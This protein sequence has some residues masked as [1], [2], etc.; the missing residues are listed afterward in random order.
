MDA[1]LVFVTLY[2]SHMHVQK[3]Q[4]IR[5]GPFEL[6]TRSGELM[7][8]GSRISLQEQ[9]FQ[10]LVMLL[11]RPGEVVTRQEFNK[12]MWPENTF[13]DFER[14]LNKAINKL[15]AAL[16]DKAGKPRYIETLPQ[17][18]YRFVAPVEK[19]PAAGDGFPARHPY[20]ID[21]LA[22]LPLANHTGDPAQ[23]YFS[24]GLT[25]ELICAIS[26]I[27][28]LRVISRTS[29]MAFK[30]TRKSLSGI[31]RELAVDAVV[32]GSVSRS[33]DRVRVTAQLIRARDDSHLWAGRYERDL[34]DILHLQAEVAQ[35]IATQINKVIDPQRVYADQSRHVDPRAYE[36]F[37]KGNYFRDKVEPLALL[38]SLECYGR[39]V[40]LDPAYARAHGALSVAYFYLGLFGVEPPAMMF[41]KA[42]ASAARALELDETVA[43][44]HIGMAVVHVLYDWDWASAERECKRALELSPGEPY[45]Y[46]H[47]ADYLSI[48]GHHAEAIDVFR[49]ALELDPISRLYIGFFGL[50]LH[51]A[52]RYDESIAQCQKALEID[53]HYVNAMWFMALSLEQKGGM[54]EAIAK[55]E[56]AVNLVRAPHFQGLLGWNYGR[57]GDRAKAVEILLELRAASEHSY[58]SPFDIAVIHAGLGELDTAFEYFE[59]AF[60]QRVFR[61]IELTLPMFDTLRGDP[62]WQDLV[63][64]VGL[65]L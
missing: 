60:R 2:C 57:M 63:R 13:V 64:R 40:E 23:E 5:F 29:A 49:R 41:P 58:V 10:A 7:R 42:R 65:Q 52:R 19:V 55:L 35:S 4:R 28:S 48:R 26:R 54:K 21:S 15:R 43:A 31:A 17:R 46:A 30:D 59:E 33:G 27:A 38:R 3:P 36:A 16:R 61:I 14:G 62:R 9:P 25:E 32:E 53:P 45:G 24:D 18:G 39:A 47:M 11:E 50:L 56:E 37:L 51:R 12:A 1:C 8:D 20:Q 44:G 6:D 34:G 22:I